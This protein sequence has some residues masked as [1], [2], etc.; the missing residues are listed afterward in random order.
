MGSCTDLVSRAEFEAFKR[1]LEQKYIPQV[2]KAGI[3]NNAVSISGQAIQAGLAVQAG[4]IAKAYEAS[5]AAI[6]KGEAAIAASRAAKSTASTAAANAASATREALIAKGKGLAAESVAKKASYE[7]LYASSRASSAARAAASAG[8]IGMKAFNLVSGVLGIVGSVVSVFAMAA[9]TQQVIALSKRVAAN[10]KITGENENAIHIMKVEQSNQRKTLQNLEETLQQH[11]E[12]LELVN[13]QIRALNKLPAS[14]DLKFKRLKTLIDQLNK[15]IGDEIEAGNQTTKTANEAI[16]KANLALNK[17]PAPSP[18]ADLSGVQ[19]QIDGLQRQNE[20]LKSDNN[21]FR[22]ALNTALAKVEQKE[23]KYIVR[24]VEKATITNASSIR[25]IN[26]N[27]VG[28]PSKFGQQIQG[29]SQ[30]LRSEFRQADINTQN[31]IVNTAG[32]TKPQVEKIIDT[33][34]EDVN[35]MNEQQSNQINK[36]LDDLNTKVP[37]LLTPTNIAVT[38]GGLDILRQ[39]LNKPT[40]GRSPCFAPQL[41]PPV[42]AQTRT[43]FAAIGTL[44]GVTIAQAGFIQKSVNA[45]AT[46]TKTTLDVVKHGTYGLEAMQRFANTAWKATHMD[47]VLNTLSVVIALHNAA[48]LSRNLGETLG[49]L[50]SQALSTIGIKDSEGSPLDINGAISGTVNAM[51]TNILG[52]EVYQGIKETWNKSSRILSSASAIVWTVRS[53]A[54][55]TREITE[56]TAENTGKIGNALKRWRVVGENAYS[57][58]PERMTA[59]NK[60]LARVERARNNIDSLDDAASSFS[61]VLGEVQNIQ[62]EYS[63]LQEQETKFKENVKDLEPKVQEPNEPV[64]L[65]REEEREASKSP[66]SQGDVFRGEGEAD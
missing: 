32:I 21:S 37:S 31:N 35:K 33:K 24:R 18:S 42:A 38:V 28:L 22:V 25:D 19:S 27:L 23:D 60:W 2:E 5:A 55:S 10:E 20:L 39:I 54:D 57:W 58:M 56:W 63:E 41:V 15:R 53:I 1:S 36:K 29:A 8:Q 14:L 44:Q 49:D 11:Q 4:R 47:K 59:T 45:V 40:G 12:N 46:T 17:I 48:M 43:N 50:T 61:S 51:L 26:G 66:A 34:L 64:Q 62:Q 9:L 13:S 52:A 7:A 3:I 6:G 65:A 30:T 16:A